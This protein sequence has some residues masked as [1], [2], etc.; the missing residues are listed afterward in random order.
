MKELID[1]INFLYRKRIT[2]GLTTEEEAEQ[3]RL[4]REYLA[5]IRGQVIQTLNGIERTG[6]KGQAEAGCNCGEGHCHHH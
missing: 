5:A 4:R 3:S 1:R 2:V 6:G